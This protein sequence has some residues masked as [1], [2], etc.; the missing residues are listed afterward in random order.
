I[1]VGLVLGGLTA[2]RTTVAALPDDEK[3]IVHVLNRIGFGPR[4]GDV[5]RVRALGIERY[6]D[7]QLHPDGIADPAIEARL[8]GLS[9]LRMS[10]A[11]IDAEFEQPLIEMRR[12]RQRANA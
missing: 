6:V 10:G 12:Q 9:T 4:A 1:A 3:A 8:A 2:S 5:A 7:Q 11:E